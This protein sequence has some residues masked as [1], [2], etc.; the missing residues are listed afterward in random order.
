VEQSRSRRRQKPPSF[1]VDRQYG[2]AGA[3]HRESVFGVAPSRIAGAGRLRNDAI[4]VG[5][6]GLEE[7]GE[8]EERKSS[9]QREPGPSTAL[10]LTIA[11]ARAGQT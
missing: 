6:L 11:R 8:R 2:E 4:A 9:P 3:G 7:E 10:P 5:C 1:S